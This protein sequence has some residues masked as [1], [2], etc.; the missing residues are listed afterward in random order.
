MKNVRCNLLQYKG[1]SNLREQGRVKKRTEIDSG[2]CEICYVA[3]VL[4]RISIRSQR[5]GVCDP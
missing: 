4:M 2:D 1:K 3:Y 5:Y